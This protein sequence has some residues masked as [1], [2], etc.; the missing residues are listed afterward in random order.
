MSFIEILADIGS[1]AFIGIL[2]ACVIR[3]LLYLGSY[4]DAHAQ[5]A[6]AKR[7]AIEQKGRQ[8]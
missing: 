7:R 6:T 1:L 3:V 2:A 4:L 5:L 8:F